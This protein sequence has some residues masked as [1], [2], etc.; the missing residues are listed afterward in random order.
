MF[1]N[2]F[3][4]RHKWVGQPWTLI[5]NPGEPDAPEQAKSHAA[6]HQDRDGPAEI[7]QIDPGMTDNR[8]ERIDDLGGNG[9]SAAINRPPPARPLR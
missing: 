5:H 3:L 9:Q 4:K 2:Q 1:S 7:R 6:A 8:R